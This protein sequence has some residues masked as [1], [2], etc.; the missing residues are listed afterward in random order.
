M[1]PVIGINTLAGM[2]EA[3]H[4]INT[5]Y[6]RAVEAAGA[7]PILL[8][9]V[10][11]AEDAEKMAERIDGLLLPGGPDVSPLAYGEEPIP[12][13]GATNRENDQFEMELLRAVNS[14]GK[15]ALGICRGLQSIN[16]CFG[17]TLWQDL[18]AQ[19]KAGICHAQNGAIRGE[20]TH[21]VILEEG[22]LLKSIIGSGEILANSYHHQ[23]V[24]ETAPGFKV[25]ARARDGVIE[26][27][28]SD[29]AGGGQIL[30][31]QWHPEELAGRFPEHKSLFLWLAEASRRK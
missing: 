28:E 18:A 12:E 27:I 8:P 24:K 9:A 10:G 5:A 11:T 30:A 31:V 7:V 3:V 23:A 20:R 13:I 4:R 6:I 21:S 17:G 29:G 14:Q 19:A 1:K 22:T 2:G 26:G 25:S 15:P 16:A